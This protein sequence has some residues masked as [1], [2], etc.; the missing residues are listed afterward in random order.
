MKAR[1]I[2]FAIL[3]V[4]NHCR[5][6][7]RVNSLFGDKQAQAVVSKP[8]KV[9]GYRLADDSLFRPTVKDFKMTAGPVAVDDKLAQSMAQLLLDEKSYLWDVGKGCEPHFGVRLEFVQ[10]DK[11]IDVFFCFECDILQVYANGKPV[12][13]EDFDDVRP[14][15]VK[16]M[17]KIFPEDKVIQG[18][19]AQP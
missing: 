3:L 16:M 19:K 11:S 6:A 18:L 5:A 13:S 17:Q 10:G 14:Q 12:G 8:T 9:Q 15:L 7:E 1:L 2:L 4:A